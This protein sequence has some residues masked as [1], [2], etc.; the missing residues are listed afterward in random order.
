MPKTFFMLAGEASGD[1]HAAKLITALKTLEAD[2]RFLGLGGPK[3]AA[4]GFQ[5]VKDLDGMQVVGFW[6][7]ARKYGF[8][9]RVFYELLDRVKQERPDAL[10]CV[11]YPG[12]N[13]RFARE[14]RKLGIPV[15]YYIVPQVWAWKALRAKSMA[16]FVDRAFCVFEFEPPFFEKFGLRTTFVGHPLIDDCGSQIA[17]C[18]LK[19]P[20]G[21]QTVAFLPGSRAGE[22]SALA[23][24]MA[25]AFD[26]AMRAKPDLRAL[27]SV[28]PGMPPRIVAKTSHGLLLAALDFQNKLGDHI[29]ETVR[30]VKEQAEILW[31]PVPKDV[32]PRDSREGE[33]F[34]RRWKNFFSVHKALGESGVPHARLLPSLA[35]FSVVKSGT[36]TLEAGLA[37]NPMCVVYK[38]SFISYAIAHLMVNIPVFSLVNIVL[39]RYAVPEL[40]QG[41]ANPCRIAE[42]IKR[43][44]TDEKYR[45]QQKAALA[46]LP[47]K[48][49]GPGASARAAHGIL[50][51]LRGRG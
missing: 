3:M 38:S 5:A 2:A 1:G 49:G 19:L 31:G 47:K 20:P 50:D 14:V 11:D 17:D 27:M 39:G 41:E 40:L 10:L 30:K 35:D 43:G 18:G 32:P 8:F 33:E 6:E 28:A 12:F 44:L 26:M 15:L 36:S 25:E 16:R 23:P 45:E 51:F 9:K 21:P 34:N 48:L 42:E 4:A 46:E 29:G 13:L 37:G 22:F 24:V 7:V